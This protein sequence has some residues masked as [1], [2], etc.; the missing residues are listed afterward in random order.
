MK[1]TILFVF[2]VLSAGFL[3]APTPTPRPPTATPEPTATNT[4]E[5]P[6]AEPTATWTPEP[7]ST[8]ESTATPDPPTSTSVPVMPSATPTTEPTQAVTV[9]PPTVPPT[10]PATTAAPEPVVAM[11]LPET[12]D[13]GMS[14]IGVV[15]I[16][17][18]LLLAV[19][20]VGYCVLRAAGRA[21]EEAEALE[22]RMLMVERLTEVISRIPDETKVP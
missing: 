7:T 9:V 8:S 10:Q 6:T 19:G 3:M 4:P 11:L 15:A 1:T 20:F 17:V 21:E 13:D 14:P 5:P 16:C 18:G 12:G 2:L 22:Q